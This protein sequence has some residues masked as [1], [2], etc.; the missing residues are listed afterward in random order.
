MEDA[1]LDAFMEERMMGGPDF[2]PDDE[3]DPYDLDYG[4]EDEEPIDPENW[5]AY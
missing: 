1:Y 4:W 3:I 5:E 2:W